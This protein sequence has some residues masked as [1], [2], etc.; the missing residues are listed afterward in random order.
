MCAHKGKRGVAGCRAAAWGAPTPPPCTTPA[1]RHRQPQAWPADV[2]AARRGVVR[3]NTPASQR[4]ERPP[5]TPTNTHT[6]AHT[7]A[8]AYT[9]PSPHLAHPPAPPLGQQAPQAPRT[10]PTTNLQVVPAAALH[11]LA[12]ARHLAAAVLDKVQVH[13]PRR[14]EGTCRAG[15][16]GKA[17]VGKGRMGVGRKHGARAHAYVWCVCVCVG[18][19]GETVAA[20]LR[21]VRLYDVRGVGERGSGNPL[22]CGVSGRGWALPLCEAGRG[23][24]R[25]E[26]VGG[27]GGA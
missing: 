14:C 1:L 23:G 12:R 27:G 2:Q 9:H 20:W 16:R 17:K 19:S 13:L 10:A 21:T 22:R 5:P 7:R 6:R 25:C 24:E 15:A 8:R 3:K 26:T 18:G 4:K 11:L